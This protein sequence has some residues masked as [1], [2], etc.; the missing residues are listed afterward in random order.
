MEKQITRD[1]KFRHVFGKV[2]KKESAVINL[3]I[4]SSGSF[5]KGNAKYSVLP[6]ETVG[7]ALAIIPT[8]YAGKFD[9]FFLCSCRV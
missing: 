6:W 8:D 9:D 5:L 2:W 7:G 1:S 4:K 3:K